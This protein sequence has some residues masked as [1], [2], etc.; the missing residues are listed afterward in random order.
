MRR[1]LQRVAHFLRA[2]HQFQQIRAKLAV[3]RE[4]L[5]VHVRRHQFL[6][7]R[8]FRVEGRVHRLALGADGDDA[9]LLVLAQIVEERQEV[10][11]FLELCK[12]LGFGFGGDPVGDEVVC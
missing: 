5:L 8:H 10:H 12:H 7:R 4:F 2:L 9:L 6:M 1:V 3:P 11:D